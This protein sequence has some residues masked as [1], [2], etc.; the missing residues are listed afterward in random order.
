MPALGVLAVALVASA[1]SL[2][3]VEGAKVS[4]KSSGKKMNEL[5]IAGST[6]KLA[7]K[8]DGTNLVLV[9]DVAAIKTGI[10]KRD[11]HLKNKFIKV[12]P[13]SL[14][15]PKSGLKLPDGGKDVK[16]N[17]SGTLKVNNVE[18]PVKVSYTA[19]GSGGSYDVTGSFGFEL[20]AHGIEQPCFL[21]VC[22]GTHVDVNASFKLKEK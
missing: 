22:A 10:G 21:G 9:A 12:H 5:S 2:S 14:T 17:V 8:D 13:I 7:A 16:G 18:K 1:G 4:F 20:T 19:K 15:V 6:N 11:D 3:T